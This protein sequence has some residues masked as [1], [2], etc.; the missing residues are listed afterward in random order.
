LS[1]Y[2]SV[3]NKTAFFVIFFKI[4][5]IMNFFVRVFN[6]AHRWIS[7][8]G[9]KFNYPRVKLIKPMEI[10]TFYSQ[11]GQDMYLASLLFN[12]INSN[13]DCLVVDVGCNHPIH[14]SNSLFFE[15]FFKCQVLAIDPLEEFGE[16]W[17]KERPNSTFISTAVG[18]TIGSIT[19]QVPLDTGFSNMFSSVKGGVSKTPN[20][21]VRE[22]VV[23]CTTLANIFRDHNVKEVLMMSIDIEGFELDAL[24][25]IDFNSVTIK[26]ICLENNSLSWYGSNEIRKF[27]T[28]KNFIFIARIGY[29]DDVFI[30]QTLV[31][32]GF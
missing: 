15:K 8:V 23:Q 14:F 27:L 10:G 26:C 21:V 2:L 6:F 12:L 24:R 16:I 9:F 5:Y 11:D 22:R 32:G 30:H 3:I 31:N 7:F 13:N 1:G 18:S 28:S 19:L 20:C 25:G 4:E 17:K 29:L